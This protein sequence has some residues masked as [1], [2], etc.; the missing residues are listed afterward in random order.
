MIEK[1]QAQ[2]DKL[3]DLKTGMMQ[4]L[5]INGIGHTEFKGSP[6]GRI[7]A[8]WEVIQLERKAKLIPG[9]AFN[10]SDFVSSGAPLVRMGN[11]YQ[12]KLSLSR[13]P[14]YL[15]LDFI[16]KHKKFVIKEND[17]VFSMTGTAGKEDYGFAVNIPEGTPLCLLNQRVAKVVAGE[18]LNVKFLLHLLHSRMFLDEI[19]AVGTGT[20]QANLSSSH[21][22]N[23]E[24]AFPPLKEQ[25][26]IACALD[27][28]S[29]RISVLKEKLIQLNNTKKALMQDL[30]TGKVRVK[31]DS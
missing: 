4:E 29:E 22:L 9:Y 7:P 26:E 2:I 16:E 14:K 18:D 3:K 1:T 13:A 17:I 30:L 12:N 15:P 20:K 8:E 24:L 10:S 11:L 31:V 25:S 28:V 21:I 19:Y 23:V 27:S 5:L 6:V